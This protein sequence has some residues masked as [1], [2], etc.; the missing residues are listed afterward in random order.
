[1]PKKVIVLGSGLVG[2]AMAL[3]LIETYDVATVDQNTRNFKR[4]SK[5]GITTIQAD[6]SI[7]GKI[8][9]L[10]AGFDLAIGSLPGFMGF[11]ALQEVIESGINI[12][13][14]SFMPED[15]LE[16]DELAKNKGVTAVADCGVAPGMGNIILG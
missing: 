2:S 7:P 9:E 5:A 14:I 12:V 8:A 1:M 10:V 16:L 4:L 6:L 13:D 15:F 11:A 3:D